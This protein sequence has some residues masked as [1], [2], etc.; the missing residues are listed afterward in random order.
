[1]RRATLTCF[2]TLC[3]VWAPSLPGWRRGASTE[4]AQEE[5]KCEVV[6][7][8][9]YTGTQAVDLGNFIVWRSGSDGGACGSG[10]WFETVKK[11][12]DK[13][14]RTAKCS[15]GAQLYDIELVR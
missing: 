12:G 9:K 10:C 1:M 6:R 3:L 4:S 2:V 5:K 15:S 8:K 14:T 13:I 11:A 7:P